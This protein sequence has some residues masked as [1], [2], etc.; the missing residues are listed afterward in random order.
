ME[1]GEKRIWKESEIS[2]LTDAEFEKYQ[3]DIKMAPYEGRYLANQ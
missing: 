2:R 1:T 3:L